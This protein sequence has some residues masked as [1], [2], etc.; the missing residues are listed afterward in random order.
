VKRSACL[1]LLFSL[2]SGGCFT[3]PFTAKSTSKDNALKSSP[4]PPPQPV[5][6]E[7]V[8]ANNLRQKVREIEAEIRYDEQDR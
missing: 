1:I 8:T 6:P 2:L 4:L 3:F 7:E 5:N